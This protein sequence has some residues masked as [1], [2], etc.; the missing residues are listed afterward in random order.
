[1]VNHYKKTCRKSVESKDSHVEQHALNLLSPLLAPF[2][3][4]PLNVI[5]FF[6]LCSKFS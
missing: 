5:L 2:Q 4:P 1:M 6:Q 3:A